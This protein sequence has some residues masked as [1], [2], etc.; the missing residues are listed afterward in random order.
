MRAETLNGMN[1][2]LANRAAADHTTLTYNAENRLAS[3]SGAVS[4]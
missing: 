4:R 3:V 1:Y 2:V